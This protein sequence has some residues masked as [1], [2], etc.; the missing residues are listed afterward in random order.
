MDRAVK[1]FETDEIID[2]PVDSRWG[3]VGSD[4]QYYQARVTGVLEDGR[5]AVSIGYYDTAWEQSW[6]R[7]AERV[8]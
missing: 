3:Y 4:G 6:F 8:S 1:F 7:T 5:I 2:I